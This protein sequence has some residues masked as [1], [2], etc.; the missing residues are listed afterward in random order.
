MSNF[1]IL[2]PYP[3]QTGDLPPDAEQ[4]YARRTPLP[5]VGSM[6][7]IPFRP[8]Y[9]QTPDPD[10]ETG[11]ARRI[12][13]LG[14]GQTAGVLLRRPVWY[15]DD[16]PPQ[17]GWASRI[18]LTR[19]PGLAAGPLVRRRYSIDSE[20][21]PQFQDEPGAKR[22]PLLGIGA[23]A[24]FV[25]PRSRVSC[26]M[27]YDIDAGG[28]WRTGPGMLSNAGQIISGPYTL[29]AMALFQPGPVFGVIASE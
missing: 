4:G 13:L 2:K 20:N 28:A 5:G 29:D 22:T 26:D 18:P 8:R 6:F 27:P 21:A 17:D 9:S 23:T 14:S 19:P 7:A 15:V 1:N 16:S 10:P 25:V 12:P 11:Y 24:A 3:V